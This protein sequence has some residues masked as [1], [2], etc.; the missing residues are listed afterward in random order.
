MMPLKIT[1][2]SRR[3][4]PKGKVQV[5]STLS[6][7][8]STAEEDPTFAITF[9]EFLHHYITKFATKLHARVPFHGDLILNVSI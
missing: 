4:S 7:I 8:K 2:N 9:T 1:I 3:G 6:S 5:H